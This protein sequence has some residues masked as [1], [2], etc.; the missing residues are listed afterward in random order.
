MAGRIGSAHPLGIDDLNRGLFEPGKSIWGNPDEKYYI[1][2][3][4]G[5]IW[6]VIFLIADFRNRSLQLISSWNELLWDKSLR[7]NQLKVCRNFS[8]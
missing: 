2:T 5:I 4:A 3:P 8:F 7:D 1:E 6:M